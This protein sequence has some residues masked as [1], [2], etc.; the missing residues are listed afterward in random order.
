MNKIKLT[1]ANPRDFND[2]IVPA[3][4]RPKLEPFCGVVFDTEPARLILKSLECEGEPKAEEEGEGCLETKNKLN[5]RKIN[6]I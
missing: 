2:H 6:K 5:R 1:T 4:K 3:K